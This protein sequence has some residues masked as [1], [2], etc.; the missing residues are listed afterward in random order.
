M[1]YS[2]LHHFT[3][4]LFRWKKKWEIKVQ[5]WNFITT[6]LTAKKKLSFCCMMYRCF[7]F[8]FFF[9]IKT[10]LIRIFRYIGFD[11]TCCTSH[12]CTVYVPFSIRRSFSEVIIMKLKEIIF[13]YTENL[14]IRDT[15]DKWVKKLLFEC[16]YI[17]NK[18]CNIVYLCRILKSEFH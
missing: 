7:D 9:Y 4:I 5:N 18:E 12:I 14:V 1:K 17:E 2:D 16:E 6:I 13:A 15:I 11:T 10:S 3:R 8:F